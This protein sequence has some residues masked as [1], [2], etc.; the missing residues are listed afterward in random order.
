MGDDLLGELI[1]LFFEKKTDFVMDKETG[2]PYGVFQS[3]IDH[4]LEVRRR[5]REATEAKAQ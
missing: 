4:L 3:Q 2:M 1:Q 5:S